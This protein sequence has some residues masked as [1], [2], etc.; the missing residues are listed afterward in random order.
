MHAPARLFIPFA[1][2]AVLTVACVQTAPDPSTSTTTQATSSPCMT[3]DLG[4]TGNLDLAATAN[5]ITCRERVMFLEET[6]QELSSALAD[7]PVRYR[8]EA[9]TICEDNRWS[10]SDMGFT[11]FGQCVEVQLAFFEASPSAE[12]EQE[13]LIALR[14]E[15]G[16]LRIRLNED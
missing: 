7:W 4:Y 11:S 3:P 13:R 16:D 5:L 9:V 2:V 8:A 12:S 15:L 14:S 10:A 6:I 1:L